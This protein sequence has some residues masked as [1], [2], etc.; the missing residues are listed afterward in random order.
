[1][2]QFDER[3]ISY[4]VEQERGPDERDAGEDLCQIMG[5]HPDCIQDLREGAEDE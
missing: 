1:M 3:I 4:Y 5:Y 2:N